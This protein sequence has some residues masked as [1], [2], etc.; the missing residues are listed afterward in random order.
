MGRWAAWDERTVLID[1]AR[2]RVS[3]LQRF[4]GGGSPASF[5]SFV[6][7]PDAG[8]LD[9]WEQERLL[10]LVHFNAESRSEPEHALA[11]LARDL[12][13]AAAKQRP[14][15]GRE[16]RVT[17]LPNL[18]WWQGSP[19]ARFSDTWGAAPEANPEEG[20]CPCYRVF[21]GSRFER[22]RDWPVG[23]AQVVLYSTT[24]RNR[25]L[26]VLALERNRY[27]WIHLESTFGTELMAF[28][29]GSTWWLALEDVY[30][31]RDYLL[32]YDARSRRAWK[33][34]LGEFSPRAFHED[35][36]EVESRQSGKHERIRY[37]R[38]RP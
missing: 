27:H 24:A 6:D 23:G 29:Q 26:A 37:Q 9:E 15:K 7:P 20:R 19:P 5:A 11:F 18:R 17:Q 28:T 8:P 31:D 38:L 16:I 1:K 22:V 21:S 4:G 2:C 32:A 12:S 3:A 10:R 35:G 14:T 36:V 30:G 34:E 25:T 33:V 13:Q